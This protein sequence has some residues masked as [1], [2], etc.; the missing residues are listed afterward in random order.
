MGAQKVEK[1]RK[2]NHGPGIGVSGNPKGRPKKG[3]ALSELAKEFLSAKV[4]N[5]ERIF[6]WLERMDE[7]VM[8]GKDNDS[9]SAFHEVCDRGFGKAVQTVEGNMDVLSYLT[10]MTIEDL[11]N[12]RKKITG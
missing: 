3:N 5:K 9:V 2:I 6:L 8:H 11:E 1:Q 7:I 10:N 4:K 12:E